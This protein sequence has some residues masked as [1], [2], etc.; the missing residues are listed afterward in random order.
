LTA[1]D[2]NNEDDRMTN[3]M[4]L[5]EEV[6]EEFFEPYR[7]PNSHH[8]V[9]GGLGLETFGKDLALVSSLDPNFVWTVLDGEKDQWIVPG[10][11]WVNR[12]CYLVSRKPHCD[13]DVEFKASLR[14]KDLTERG[15]IRQ[16]KALKNAIK[17][18]VPAGS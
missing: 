9:W 12:V 5:R 2:R 14:V 16:L 10:F 6:F 4:V 15:K 13:I 1:R 17:A 3:T 11:H 7:H 18:K 8:D